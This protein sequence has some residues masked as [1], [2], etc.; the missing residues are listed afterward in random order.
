MAGTRST[1]Q[2]ICRLFILAVVAIVGVWL[3]WVLGKPVLWWMQDDTSSRSAL[4][5]SPGAAPAG[6]QSL[7]DLNQSA[8]RPAQLELQPCTRTDISPPVATGH[9]LAHQ[10]QRSS[11]H[12]FGTATVSWCNLYSCD[13]AA[14]RLCSHAWLRVSLEHE[15][16]LRTY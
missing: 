10:V 2:R 1:G 14:S 7:L 16:L 6:S 4:Q 8:R 15:G 5:A 9:I 3:L 13:T 12:G 11:V